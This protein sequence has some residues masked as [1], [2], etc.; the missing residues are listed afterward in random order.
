[1]GKTKGEV[2]NYKK[3][4]TKLEK[5]KMKLLGKY[6]PPLTDKYKDLLLA[7]GIDAKLSIDENEP[8][9]AM[10]GDLNRTCLYV[11]EE[12]YDKAVRIIKEYEDNDLLRQQ[13]HSEELRSLLFVILK[14]AMIIVLILWWLGYKGILRLF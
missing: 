1:V 8:P 2:Y 6:Q 14:C 9:T 7:E 12:L 4:S 5:V 11:P 3:L 13:K 10:G